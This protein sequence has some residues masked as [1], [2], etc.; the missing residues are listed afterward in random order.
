MHGHTHAFCLAHCACTELG[1]WGTPLSRDGV[2]ITLPHPQAHPSSCLAT[3]FSPRGWDPIGT[4]LRERSTS[5][6]APSARLCERVVR[7]RKS[8]LASAE[9][10]AALN[11]PCFMPWVPP[12]STTSQQKVTRY[13]DM[14]P[15]SPISF[16]FHHAHA[17]LLK[18]YSVK[19]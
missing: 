4:A 7:G 3:A 9:S 2:P 15:W 11:C 19:S 16:T 8:Q 1:D 14:I 5:S 10:S 18:F 13:R 12:V 17:F 6:K